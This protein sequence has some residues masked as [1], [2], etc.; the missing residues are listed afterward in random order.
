M[1]GWKALKRRIEVGMLANAGLVRNLLSS[2]LTPDQ[3]RAFSLAFKPPSQEAVLP[4]GYE[5][6]LKCIIPSQPLSGCGPV[7]IL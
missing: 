6:G 3:S 4:R 1:Q 2:P 5:H 7:D